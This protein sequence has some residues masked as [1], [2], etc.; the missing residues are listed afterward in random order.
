[1]FFFNMSLGQ[2]N[3]SL[4]E[5]QYYKVNNNNGG[6]EVNSQNAFYNINTKSVTFSSKEEGVRSKI[7]F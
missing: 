5:V 4:E 1:M 2:K 6:Y 3:F 7:Y